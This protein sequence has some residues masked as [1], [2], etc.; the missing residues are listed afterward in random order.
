VVLGATEVDTGAVEVAAVELEAGELGETEELLVAPVVVALLLLAEV[1]VVAL[2]DG[3]AV[4]LAALLCDDALEPGADGAAPAWW[5]PVAGGN[6]AA[7]IA[8]DRCT[9]AERA[10]IEVP[11]SYLPVMTDPAD[12]QPRQSSIHRHPRFTACIAAIR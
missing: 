4:A 11:I 1:L 6:A 10:S 8:P 3:V 12:A 7:M 9:T 5:V 2:V